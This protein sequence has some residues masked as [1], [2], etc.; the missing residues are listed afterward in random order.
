M[1]PHHTAAAVYVAASERERRQNLNEDYS[2]NDPVEG[3]PDDEMEEHEKDEKDEGAAQHH[4]KPRWAAFD[5]NVTAND[6][7]NKISSHKTS[8]P[9]LE[10]RKFIDTK[11]FKVPI[12][13][14]ILFNCTSMGLAADDSNDDGGIY[15]QLEAVFTAVFF[16][17][18]VC[19]LWVLRRRYFKDHFNN[20]DFFLVWFAILDAWV[21]T[22]SGFTGMGVLQM[23]R[24]LRLVRMIRLLRE[25][26]TLWLILRGLLASVGALGWVTVVAFVV[27]YIFAILLVIG[28]GR[29]KDVYPGYDQE[30]VEEWNAETPGSFNNFQYFGTMSRAIYT[31]FCITIMAEWD[32]IGRAIFE[33][34]PSMIVV[35]IVFII[36]MTF[37]ILNVFVGVI[38]EG[39][40]KVFNELEDEKEKENR[41]EKFSLLQHI[42]DKVFELDA[43]GSGVVTLDEMKDSMH[44]VA[45]LLDDIRLPHSFGVKR[46]MDL[47]DE[48]GDGMLTP[49]EFVRGCFELIYNGPFQNHC[50]VVSKCNALHRDAMLIKNSLDGIMRQEFQRIDER[51]D[52]IVLAYRG[53][54]NVV[55]SQ[56]NA[57]TIQG[58]SLKQIY[59]QKHDL[60]DQVKENVNG[61]EI[62][63]ANGK[64]LPSMPKVQE[65]LEVVEKNAT[66]VHENAMLKGQVAAKEKLLEQVMGLLGQIVT[67]HQASGAQYHNGYTHGGY[68]NGTPPYGAGVGM[69]EMSFGTLNSRMQSREPS[70]IEFQ[71]NNGR[72]RQHG[73]KKKRQQ[74][75]SL[76]EWMINDTMSIISSRADSVVYTEEDEAR[77]HQLIELVKVS[78]QTSSTAKVAW[79]SRAQQAEAL[80]E[81]M[82]APEECSLEFLSL[83]LDAVM[84]GLL[85]FV[86]DGNDASH[87]EL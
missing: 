45:E 53:L 39:T 79:Q 76:N 63:H 6:L 3:F 43:D 64:S 37:G 31:L 72:N 23:L 20:L 41:S 21:L 83:F 49:D 68:A 84:P 28:I 25:F 86:K 60:F 8:E 2:Q 61:D 82:P 50:V 1:I 16:I 78:L 59:S 18:M 66:L 9:K 42:K 27:L 48:D 34:Q 44:V 55:A 15:S 12:Y 46:V 74:R 70:E 22:P 36:I 26:K 62:G 58:E 67:D 33:Y 24:S 13:V 77:R 65:N 51:L 57:I 5:F 10:K 38:V 87:V 56:G 54:E 47:L 71:S 32:A 80:G 40:M 69:D 11:W 4:E 14:C 52:E 19:K 81:V 17:E 7:V 75:S 30:N 35:F 73:Q 29:K 85:R